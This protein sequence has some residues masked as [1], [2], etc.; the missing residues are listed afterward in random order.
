MR[1]NN[2]DADTKL[3]MI[4]VMMMMMTTMMMMMMVMSP[5]PFWLKAFDSSVSATICIKETAG[6]AT[7]YMQR[8]HHCS[9]T[10][11]SEN[12]AQVVRHDLLGPLLRLMTDAATW[13]QHPGW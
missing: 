7:I 5:Y 12:F 4:M 8:F 11:E 10:A 6:R 3:M 13:N 1:K 9:S 2:S